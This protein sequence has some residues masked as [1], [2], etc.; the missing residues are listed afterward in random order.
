MRR[1]LELPFQVPLQC[2][3]RTDITQSTRTI[4]KQHHRKWFQ[5]QWF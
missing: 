2:F 4:S 5:F 1:E 3:L